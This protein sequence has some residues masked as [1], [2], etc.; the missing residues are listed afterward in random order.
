ML[1]SPS[2]PVGASQPM[3]MLKLFGKRYSYLVLI[4]V[5]EDW[6]IVRMNSA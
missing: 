2:P 1:N 4:Q 6:D 5:F 3:S